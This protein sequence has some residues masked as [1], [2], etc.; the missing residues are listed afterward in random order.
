MSHWEMLT[1]AQG[2]G[3]EEQAWEGKLEWWPVPPPF[4]LLGFF[5]ALSTVGLAAQ[6]QV[7]SS[8]FFFSHSSLFLE[9][10]LSM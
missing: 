8:F 5:A 7:W 9:Q 6:S 3:R 10:G 1:V 4:C 2:R